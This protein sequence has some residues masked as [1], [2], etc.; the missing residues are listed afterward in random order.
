MFLGKTPGVLL[1]VF[2]LYVSENALCNR[3][4]GTGK[5]QT[6]H[7]HVCHM[8]AFN[9]TCRPIRRRKGG[10]F[11]S[12][13]QIWGKKH[14]KFSRRFH[15]TDV[16]QSEWQYVSWSEGRKMYIFLTCTS[17]IGHGWRFRRWIFVFFFEIER[18]SRGTRPVVVHCA[19]QFPALGS[20]T[21]YNYYAYNTLSIQ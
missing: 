8:G 11:V 10:D 20:Y 5:R 12:N 19:D 2:L 6:K 15:Y 18:R 13:A 3:D 16:L 1:H 4:H 7:V 21:F 9:S 17:V 14:A